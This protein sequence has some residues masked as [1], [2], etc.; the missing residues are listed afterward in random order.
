[1]SFF[2]RAQGWINVTK[3]EAEKINKV[4]GATWSAH[5]YFLSESF[6]CSNCSRELT[7]FDVFETGRKLHGDSLIKQAITGDYILQI[8]KRGQKIEANCSACGTSNILPDPTKYG[9][10]AYGTC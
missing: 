1:M 7:F 10:G 4:V 8:N 2:K 3:E 5:D 6:P 9:G